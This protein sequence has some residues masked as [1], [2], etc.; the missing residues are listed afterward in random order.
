MRFVRAAGRAEAIPVASERM[1]VRC[2]SRQGAAMTRVECPCC[3]GQK[4]LM[5]WDGD[6]FEL[7]MCCHCQGEGT[8]PAE[9]A[10]PEPERLAD[11]H[12]AVGQGPPLSQA[13]LVPRYD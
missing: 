5:V 6:Y 10:E 13:R 7:G 2:L 1:A 3:K 9:V 11:R 12:G 4:R 8:M